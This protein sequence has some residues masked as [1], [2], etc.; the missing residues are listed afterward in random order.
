ML[1]ALVVGGDG[2]I[3]R[4][5]TLQLA[6]SGWM[7]VSTTRRTTAAPS[8]VNFDLAQGVSTLS[9][10]GN[11]VPAGGLVVFICAAVTGF[12]QCANDPEGS[13]YINVNRTVE[14][15]SYFMQQGALVVYLSSNSVF[16]GTFVDLNEMAATSPVSEYGRQKADCEKGLTAAAQDLIGACAIVRL[17]KVVDQSQG[18]YKAWV[19]CF[20][21]HIPAK[22]AVD[23]VVCPVTTG[24]VVKGL[25]R[26]A[27]NGR[28][29]VFH[30]SGER[31]LT[32]FE[33]ASAIGFR[34]DRSAVIEPDWV[35]QRFGV[36]PA[37]AHGAMSMAHTT[38]ACGLQPQALAD[39]VHEL[40][41]QI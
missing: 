7:V 35:Q 25:Q 23:L 6:A 16:D 24:Y 32:Y 18:L 36:V 34:M 15:G 21:S 27:L 26:I 22:A 14:L 17:T 13:R 20:K 38:A 4:A 19:Q 33:L 28:G 11:A 9:G 30:L 39:V 1:S 29:G 37:P 40:T 41:E 8:Q 2:L 10:P 12:A 3:G 5:L 31:D